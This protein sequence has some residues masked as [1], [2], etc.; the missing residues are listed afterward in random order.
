MSTVAFII[1]QTMFF[2]IPL[3]IVS[4]GAL[5][6]ERSGVSNIAM[7][8]IMV[9]GAFAGTLF[10]RQCSAAL[11][12]QL[13]FLLAI[14]ISA[15][16]GMLYSLL[17]AWASIRLRADQTIS[18]TALNMFA[19]A[20]CIFIAR[21]LY[22]VQQVDFTD[23]FFIQ[24]VPL[25]GDIP[26]IGACFF[27]NCYISTYLGI[28]L[29]FFLNFLL[30][31]TRF[32]LRLCACGENPDAAAAAG[33]SV[34]RMRYTGVLISGLLGGAGGLIF[35]VPTSTNFSANVAGYG[36]LALAVL[37]LGQW[38]PLWIL[39]A[40]F[41]FGLMK[42]LSSAYSGIA[43]LAELN[44]PS[45]IYKT[46][47]YVLTLIVLV[48]SAKRS[49][50]PKA[51]GIPYDDGKGFFEN[52]S[53][54]KT[55]STAAVALAVFTVTAAVTIPLSTRRFRKIGVSDGYGAEIAFI[56]TGDSTIDDKS[57]NQSIW[58]GLSQYGRENGFSVKYYRAQDNSDESL[59]R[60]IVLA[61][62][63]GAKTVFLSDSNFSA[64]MYTKQ[65]EYPDVHFIFGD[66]APTDEDGT[67]CIGPNTISLSIDEA[68]SGFLAGYAAVR[69][70]YRN[71]GFIGGMAYASVVRFG[72]GFVAGADCAAR[73][74]GLKKSD[75][76]ITYHYA[77]T[78]SATP[79]VLALAS[80]WYQNGT[81]VIF[82][83]GGA[84][85]NSVM[86]A[87]E[88]AGRAVIGVDRDQSGESPSVITSATKNM[89]GA[90][91]YLLDYIQNNPA[92]GGETVHLDAAA[93][94]VSLPM[95]T[96]RFRT[97]TEEDYN[98]VYAKLAAREI[99]VPDENAADSAELLPAEIVSVRAVR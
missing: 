73:E 21:T 27:T 42:A 2:V 3:L 55:I 44:I 74:L 5:Y 87:A 15:L 53:R 75:V 26:L 83:C 40:S 50:A 99:Q 68:Q 54:K 45:E 8:G 25:L 93:N 86:K 7:E 51:V 14:L 41:F 90:V 84:L 95:E 76:Q 32:G 69:D 98:A 80:S 56:L 1:Q 18:G 64:I 70:G 24:K 59:N 79:E 61:V 60:A 47:P 88:N 35:V 52:N 37:I 9:I 62:K 82:A 6:A 43:F 89:H 94:S 66:G 10:I 48:L 92:A 16:T 34:S 91:M 72:Y 49:T 13:V 29:L 28:A 81:E 4:L 57:F 11:P 17:H 67:V 85:G 33:I 97:F 46:V 22:G 20:C 63:G 38:K 78:F 12:G 65:E 19:P 30:N 23:R 36:F 31:R 77:G 58:E 96:S 71:L 39:L